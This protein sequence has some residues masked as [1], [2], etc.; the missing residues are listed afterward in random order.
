MADPITTWPGRSSSAKYPWNEWLDGQI[1]SLVQGTDF[2]GPPN[3]MRNAA[4]A[5]AKVRGLKIRTSVQENTVFVQANP[6][7]PLP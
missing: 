2:T 6:P 4:S 3:N 5:A 7:D 1:W